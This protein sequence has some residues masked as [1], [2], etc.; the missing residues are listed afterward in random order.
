[1]PGGAPAPGDT[2]VTP[3]DVNKFGFTFGQYGPRVPAVVVSPRIPPNLIDHRT[4][5]HASIPATVEKIFAIPPLT[6]RDR[7]ALDV[8]SL[9]SLPGPR[10]APASAINARVAAISSRGAARQYL[11]EVAA[12]V[13]ANAAEN[14]KTGGQDAQLG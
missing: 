7:R 8:T 4:Y 13:A 3:G 6:Q 11:E 14:P 2:V 5:D 9:I 12:R 1:V 10:P